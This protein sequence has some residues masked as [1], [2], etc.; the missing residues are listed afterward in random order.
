[1]SKLILFL[2]LLSTNFI[3]AME[4]RPTSRTRG[5]H[6]PKLSCCEV[7][8]GQV[9][10]VGYLASTE[11]G[12]RVCVPALDKE[13]VVAAYVVRQHGNVQSVVGYY[14]D[15]DS[16]AIRTNCAKISELS[17]E[18]DVAESSDHT[19]ISKL[20]I[21]MLPGYYGVD[22]SDRDNLIAVISADSRE[23]IDSLS[24]AAGTEPRV[25]LYRGPRPAGESRL[26][27][28]LSISSNQVR[29]VARSDGYEVHEVATS[30]DQ[31]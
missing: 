1:M 20:L 13:T 18:S 31:R 28:K 19:A 12:K 25:S 23:L 9:L 16:D 11:Q 17:S 8:L 24:A 4:R 27:F 14:R 30:T 3:I 6:L 22:H 7:G 10:P 29:W 26:D 5:R 15:G 2:L 21:I